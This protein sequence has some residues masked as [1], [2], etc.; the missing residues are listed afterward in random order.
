[1][2]A[3]LPVAMKY[4]GEGEFRALS[5]YWA[6]VCD[7]QFVVGESYRIAE[8]YERSTNS[9]NHFFATLADAWQSL[10]DE[11]REIYPSAEH[12]RKKALIR[13]GYRDERS[14]VCASK[15]EALRLAA[16]MKPLD[17]Y[18]IV[19]AAEAVVRVY[20][21]QSQSRKAMGGKAFQESKQAVLDFV[22]DL[23]GVERGATAK[24]ASYVVEREPEA[25]PQT[26][27]DA[28]PGNLPPEGE[29][30]PGGPAIQSEPASEPPTSEAAGSGGLLPAQQPPGAA[31][32]DISA[33]GHS[34]DA[35]VEAGDSVA[36]QETVASPASDERALV[37]SAKP[38]L[39]DSLKA[40]MVRKVLQLA[41]D[42][43]LSVKER[44]ALLDQNKPLWVE[45][46]PGFGGV[47][48]QVFATAVKIVKGELKPEAGRQFMERLL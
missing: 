36:R 5:S 27:A 34:R 40:E 20:T 38:M 16:F 23:L 8:H 4:E 46:M 28:D 17:D 25:G 47:V 6:G 48:G 3:P 2:N 29:N 19:D 32:A 37:N 15:A 1:M 39:I 41:G 21:A 35:A 13:T 24:S 9:H 31:A 10:P 22:D 11:A 18:A 7:R 12:L 33:S 43:D 30:A 14:I 26:R 44:I 45:K 42:K